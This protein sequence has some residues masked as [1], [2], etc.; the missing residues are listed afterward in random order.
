MTVRRLGWLLAAALGCAACEPTDFELAGG[1]GGSYGD[2][3]GQWV[4]INYWAEWCAPCRFEIP[5]LN[6][7]AHERSGEVL[8]MGVNYDGLAG[9]E[10][11]A[12]ME[13]M[14][15][16]FPVMLS[17]PGVDWKWDRPAV[18]PTTVVIS[19]DGEVKATLVGPQT[20]DSLEAAMGEPALM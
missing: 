9:A 11:T 13:R 15:V 5:E 8:V 4:V 2:W 20:R 18:L 1:G 14:D 7:M 19:P 16:R 10:L 6:E 3:N 17:D 12:V